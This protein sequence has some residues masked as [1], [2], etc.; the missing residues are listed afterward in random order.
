MLWPWPPP[1]P[2]AI[3][4][5]LPVSLLL[6]GCRRLVG[7]AAEL[8]AGGAEG[9]WGLL[10]AALGEQAGLEL[11][12]MLPG[13]SSAWLLDAR[14]A[15]APGGGSTGARGQQ[16]A[17]G[18]LAAAAGGVAEAAGA[19]AAAAAAAPPGEEGLLGAGGRRAPQARAVLLAWAGLLAVCFG[20]A[21][22]TIM[23][24]SR[25][26]ELPWRGTH[27]PLTDAVFPACPHCL[28][29]RWWR[30]R[31]G[32]WPCGRCWA[33]GGTWMWCGWWCGSRGCW[34]QT[35]EGAGV[36]LVGG[37]GGRCPCWGGCGASLLLPLLPLCCHRCPLLPSDRQR[38]A[39]TTFNCRRLLQHQAAGG[40]GIPLP[41]LDAPF[42]LLYPP[43]LIPL[44]PSYLTPSL[45]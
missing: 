18:T 3:Y 16:G 20:G 11:E 1:G 28:V 13:V 9:S 40:R 25:H 44:Y 27:T 38:R 4:L 32:W 6:G 42:A 43:Y 36:G 23:G 29:C 2:P 41:H 8:S 10:S 31:G 26:S 37:V 7:A 19:V 33:G 39:A 22:L 15:A 45:P 30:C 34:A 21:W 5:S 12:V 17:A 14:E 24:G 35:S